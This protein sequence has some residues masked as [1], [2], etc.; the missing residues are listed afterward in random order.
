MPNL[1]LMDWSKRADPDGTPAQ[2][3]NILEQT[4]AILM[5]QVYKPGNLP[6]GERVTVATGLPTITPRAMNEG[7][8]TTKA[9]TAQTD[10]V[11]AMFEDFSEIDVAL[12]ELNGNEPEFLLNES[13]LHLEAMN[14]KVATE[15]FYGNPA[16][17]PKTFLGLAPRYSS[18]LGGNA[19]NIILGGGT[20]ANIQTSVWL[21]CWSDSTVYGIFPKGNESGLV[22][23]DLG[24]DVSYDA[25]GTGR[26]MKV[27]VNHFKWHTGLAI[28]DW[29]YAVRICNIEVGGATNDITQLSGIYAPS[30][31]AFVGTN[32]L[33]LMAKAI[34][35]IPNMQRGRCVWYMNRTVFS[36]LMRM[37]L[38]SGVRSG[39]ML[40]TAAMEFGTPSQM[41]SFMGIPIRQADAILNTEAVVT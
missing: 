36:A 30:I 8:L 20:T 28:R 6:T 14:Q 34:A 2:I 40:N 9:T 3:A 17:D 7:V 38:E 13:R 11:M 5:D 22:H 21:V 4:N 26:R 24:E 18:T 29:R 23:D 1:T 12:A 41:L 10:E 37:A 35:R 19:Q 33:H 16:V 15:L 31:A 32:L 27:F 25:G 39:L